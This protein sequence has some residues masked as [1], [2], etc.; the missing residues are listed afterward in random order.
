MDNSYKSE[1]EI[2]LKTL[3]VI[4]AS[5]VSAG[6]YIVSSHVLFNIKENDNGSLKL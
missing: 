1:E 3:R 6:A 5:D 2:F 4:A